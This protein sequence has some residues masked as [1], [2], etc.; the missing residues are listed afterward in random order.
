M[1]PLSV[2]CPRCAARPRFGCHAISDTGHWA[3]NT[4]AA[5]WKAI[6]IKKPT[7]EQLVAAF[8]LAKQHRLELTREYMRRATGEA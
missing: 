8:R 7:G 2:V 6:G 4:H 1:D 5:R 3:A